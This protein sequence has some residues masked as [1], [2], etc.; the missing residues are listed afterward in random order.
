[1][2]KPL[3]RMQSQPWLSKNVVPPAHVDSPTP[4]A[5]PPSSTE[6]SGQRS[7]S[8]MSNEISSA[9]ARY[10]YPRDA[11]SFPTLIPPLSLRQ[12]CRTR[13][14][15]PILWQSWCGPLAMARASSLPTC[16][17]HA[18]KTNSSGNG[19]RLKDVVLFLIDPIILHNFRH[20]VE[21][22]RHLSKKRANQARTKKGLAGIMVPFTSDVPA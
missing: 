4:E 16:K 7:F 19:L 22:L 17:P 12:P 9:N 15:A 3:D 11:D 18:N 14:G 1:M 5:R 20:H 6:G 10:L 21:A 2:G 13:T 8:G